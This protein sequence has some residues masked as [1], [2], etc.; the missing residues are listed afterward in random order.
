[1][2]QRLAL[3]TTLLLALACPALAQDAAL[4]QP[5]D[6]VLGHVLDVTDGDSLVVEVRGLRLAVRLAGVNCPEWNAPGGKEATAYTAAWI[7]RNPAVILEAAQDCYTA[8]P[9][10]WDK[11]GRLLAFVWRG[12][13]MLQ[14]DLLASGHGEVKY[15]KPTGEH[16]ARLQAALPQ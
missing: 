16:Y 1:M 12:D 5:G 11:Y 13:R 15:I 6:R 7:E 2:K 3:I 9:D 8:T 10:V 4:I 14:E